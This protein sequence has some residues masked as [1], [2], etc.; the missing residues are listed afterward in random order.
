MAMLTETDVS[1]LTETTGDA[2]TH[3]TAKLLILDGDWFAVIPLPD[4]AWRF[5]VKTEELPR[6]TRLLDSI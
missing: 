4:D 1:V 3:R 5:M 6:L 2:E